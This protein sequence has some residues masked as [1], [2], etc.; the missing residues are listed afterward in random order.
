LDFTAWEIGAPDNG[1]ELNGVAENCVIVNEQGFWNDVQCS[2]NHHA[3]CRKP[4][5]HQFCAVE[6]DMR[7]DCGYPGN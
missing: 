2:E 6:Y 1:A 3:F 4:A 5:D 7:D